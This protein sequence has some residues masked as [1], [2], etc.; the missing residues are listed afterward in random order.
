MELTIKLINRLDTGDKVER[1]FWNGF[2]VSGLE[3]PGV[4]WFGA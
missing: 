2:V 3:V 1:N 4:Q